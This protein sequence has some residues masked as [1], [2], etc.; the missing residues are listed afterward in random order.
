MRLAWFQSASLAYSY[1]MNPGIPIAWNYL[2]SIPSDFLQPLGSP[3]A[4]TQPQKGFSFW[5]IWIP[6]WIQAHLGSFLVWAPSSYLFLIVLVLIL[7]IPLNFYRLPPISMIL[8]GYLWIP[9]LI[10]MDSYRCSSPTTSKRGFTKASRMPCWSVLPSFVG[11]VLKNL[12]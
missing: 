6:W 3:H 2:I 1:C 11:C 10:L 7:W 8:H 12:K 9:T 5:F 4:F